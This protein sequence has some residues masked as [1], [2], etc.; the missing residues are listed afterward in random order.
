MTPRQR[1]LHRLQRRFYRCW[2]VLLSAALVALPAW[3]LWP[4]APGGAAPPA[5][6][7]QC[8]NIHKSAAVM[9]R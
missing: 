4:A 8:G 9:V 3:A 6:A 5:P 7:A 1:F 2:E